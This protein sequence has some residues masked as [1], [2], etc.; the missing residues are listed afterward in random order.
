LA[1]TP[2]RL[3]LPLILYLLPLP[4]PPPQP[5][6]LVDSVDV[7]PVTRHVAIF[8]QDSLWKRDALCHGAAFNLG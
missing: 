7:S 3:L 8:V 2:A 6:L 4:P 1:S 5:L